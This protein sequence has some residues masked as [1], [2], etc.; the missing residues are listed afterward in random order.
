MNS[1][2]FLFFLSCGFLA[3]ILSFFTL[4]CL[5]FLPR[6]LPL[7]HFPTVPSTF[8]PSFIIA[9]RHPQHT[10]TSSNSSTIAT[11]SSNG[12][13]NTRCCRYTCL[14]SWWWVVVPP[15]TCEQFPD[16]I[17]CVTL[18]LVGYILENYPF[19]FDIL[20]VS[21]R[22]L[23][24]FS[25]GKCNVIIWLWQGREIHSGRRTSACARRK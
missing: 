11:V 4:L 8:I 15:K 10:Q 25:C 18:H 21:R 24:G 2:L 14:R 3:F 23:S 9:V 5:H 7:F 13:T 1:I 22:T 20:Y 17:N 19:Y 12:V 6:I 16:K